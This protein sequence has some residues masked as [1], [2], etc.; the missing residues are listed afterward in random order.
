MKNGFLIVAMMTLPL[1][2]FAREPKATLCG[3]QAQQAAVAL[4]KVNNP[5]KK[6]NVKMELLEMDHSEGGAEIWNVH[7]VDQKGNEL[8]APYR[9]G[10]YVDG[11]TVYSFSMPTA[12]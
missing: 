5:G 8:Y 11:C 12:G 1:S 2:A 3:D 6:A 10:V 7:F 4:F 9:M